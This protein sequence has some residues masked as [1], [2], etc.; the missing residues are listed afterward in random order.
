MIEKL[1]LIIQ[2]KEK[3][4]RYRIEPSCKSQEQKKHQRNR[5]ANR[6]TKKTI[7]GTVLQIP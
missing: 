1:L 3:S 2:L 4:R 6:R 7:S 5:P